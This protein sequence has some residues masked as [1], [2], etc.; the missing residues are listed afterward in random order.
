MKKNIFVLLQICLITFAI[1]AQEILNIGGK[2]KVVVAPIAKNEELNFEKIGTKKG[3]ELHLFALK[4]NSKKLI[5]KIAYYSGYNKLCNNGMFYFS[6]DNHFINKEYPNL[7]SEL[8]VYNTKKGT[9]NKVLNSLLFT[10]SNDGRYICYCEVYQVTKKE[11]HVVPYWYI[12]DTKTK[13]N[14]LII[15]NKQKN[16]W[17]VGIPVFDESI[18]SFILDLHCDGD[19]MDK[20]IFNPYTMDFKN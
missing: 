20:L 6:I 15:S 3:F 17:D 13:K 8:F 11:N 10:V 19:I 18:N 14:K 2:D 5:T 4:D 16:N 7:T 12:Y 1:N 9:I